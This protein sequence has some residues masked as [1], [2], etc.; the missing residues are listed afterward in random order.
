MK[1]TKYLWLIF[2]V[3][4]YALNYSLLKINLWAFTGI[5]LVTLIVLVIAINFIVKFRKKKKGEHSDDFIFPSKVASTM[6]LVD[7]GIQYEASMISI[8]LL[9]IGLTLFMIYVI[10][11]APYNLLMKIFVC[12]NTVC[13]LGLMGSMLVTNYQQYM[14]HRESTRVL[15]ELANQFGTEILSPDRMKSG[16]ILTPL[17]SSEHQQIKGWIKEDK[18]EEKKIEEIKEEKEEQRDDFINNERR[19]IE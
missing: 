17:E 18:L 5:V 15:G 2:V 12:F 14:A 3:A 7:I 11:F 19:F 9:M 1:I 6:R 16:S 4:L 13:G 8:F 10:F